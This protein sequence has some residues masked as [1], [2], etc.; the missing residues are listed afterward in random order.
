MSEVITKE[1]LFEEAC[2]FI[3]SADKRRRQVNKTFTL[4]SHFGGDSKQLYNFVNDY[5]IK[6]ITDK[7]REKYPNYHIKSEVRKSTLSGVL[8]Y[9]KGPCDRFYKLVWELTITKRK[10]KEA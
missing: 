2:N 7:L 9:N 10:N 6:E 5:G 3:D 4:K 1:N 8:T